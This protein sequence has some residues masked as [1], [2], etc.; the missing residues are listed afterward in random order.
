MSSTSLVNPIAL[1]KLQPNL[2]AQVDLYA[3]PSPCFRL[4]AHPRSDDPTRTLTDLN[5]VSSSG[6]PQFN[7][8]FLHVRAQLKPEMSCLRMRFLLQF[9]K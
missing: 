2:F 7:F 5:R 8:V 6:Q 1:P 9:R 4:H 3:Q